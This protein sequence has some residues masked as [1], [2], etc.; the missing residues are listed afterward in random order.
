MSR[1]ASLRASFKILWLLT[2]IT[3]L[4]ISSIFT[5]IDQA[6]AGTVIYDD[7]TSDSE[8]W[9]YAG[10]AYRENGYAVVMPAKNWGL[11]QLWL[12]QPVT[13]PLIADFEYKIGGGTGAD[14]L[15]FMFDKEKI[16]GNNG[17]A[18]GFGGKGYGIEFDCYYNS[19][20]KDPSGQHIALIKDKVSNHLSSVNDPRTEDN[21]WHN[22]RVEVGESSVK[23]Y[24]E[25]EQVLSWTGT[26]DRTY[27]SL[28]F[29]AA[30]G[31]ANNNHYIRNVRISA[32]AISGIG[33]ID[34]YKTIDCTDR[35][36]ASYVGDPIDTASGAQIINHSLLSARGARLLSFDVTYNSLL[37]NQGPLGKGWGHN[38]ETY[39]EQ[40][41][42]GNVKIHWNATRE[43]TFIND[44][45]GNFSATERAILFDTLV[46]NPDGTYTL[47]H[48]DQSVYQFDVQGKLVEHK[49]RNGQ[50]L[51]ITYDA[52]GLLQTIT[53]PV[54]ERSLSIHYNA[55]GLIDQVT[56][57]LNRTVFFSYDAD[58]NLTGITD[59][60]GRTT[61]YTYNAAGQVLTGTNADGRQIFAVTP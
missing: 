56:D 27:N 42:G 47:T 9:E 41:A 50:S 31:A 17:G 7:F 14:G 24:V 57:P 16:L 2:L 22:V 18:L 30:T 51:T 28:G 29:S 58:H 11:G 43:N 6:F 48:Q 38:F 44:G 34:Q 21:T 49:N 33:A 23:V 52:A 55:N 46:N 15:V 25:G 61:T 59:A 35:P 54:S 32:S 8:F 36:C 53:E 60:L 40:L 45:T 5:G 3:F 1:L 19:E 37:L 20:N 4:L 12:K 10:S 39:L 26:I 13:S